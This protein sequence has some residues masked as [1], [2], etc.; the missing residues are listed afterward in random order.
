MMLAQTRRLSCSCFALCAALLGLISLVNSAHATPPCAA[1]G[2]KCPRALSAESARGLALGTGARASAIS[3][4]ALDYNPAAL[5]VG[6]LYHIEGS[7]DYMPE[8]HSV[9]LG[10]QVVDSSTAKIGAGVG[11]RGFLSGNTGLGGIDGRLALAF[12]FS[13]AISLGVGGRYIS[14]NQD[15]QLPNGN[16]KPNKLAQ[17]FTMDASFRVQPSQMLMLSISSLNFINIDSAYVPILVDT[18]ASV[19]LGQY[20]GIGVDFISDMTS[21]KKPAYTVGGGGELLVASSVPLRAGYA[22]D[23]ER[24]LQMLTGGIGYTDRYVGFDISVQQQVKG[25]SETRI[26]AAFRYYVH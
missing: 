19:L 8:F 11:L 12:P 1:L 3:T 7:V 20:A 10:G 26:L 14:V 25:G 15:V 23:I 13:D 4:S 17:G 9:A 6:H 21:F 24:K 2:S 5:V 16:V 22:V 18:S